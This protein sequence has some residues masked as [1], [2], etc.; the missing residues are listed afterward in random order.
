MDQG[1]RRGGSRELASGPRRDF[2]AYVRDRSPALLRTA[3]LLTGNADE[4]ED[5]LQDA[6]ARLLNAWSRVR[7]EDALDAYVRRTMVNL[8]TSRWRLR[9]VHTV[10]VAELPETAVHDPHSSPFDRDAMWAALLRLPP[11]M[12]AVLVLRFYE[13]LTEA[14]A[15]AAL[16]CSIG[17][18]KSQT[19]RALTKLR[20]DEAL[21]Q[22]AM[23]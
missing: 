4:A 17:T 9:R 22:E 23:L 1:D 5:L 18:V 19:S 6:L 11:R 14:E 20:A 21:M 10:P 3:Y 16:G 2:H 15:A 12:R 7:E 8:R 13:D